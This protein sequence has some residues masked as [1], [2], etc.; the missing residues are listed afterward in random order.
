[1]SESPATP[2]PISPVARREPTPTTLHGITLQDDFR[3]MRDKQSSELLAY[4]EAENAHTAAAMAP[5][6]DLQAKLYAEMLSHIKETDESV[7]YRLG[8]WFYSTRTLEGSQYPIHVRRPAGN[9]DLSSPFDPAQPEQVILDVNLLAEGKPFMSVGAL[10]ICPDG[11]FLAY[12]TDETGFRQYTLHIRDLR[13]GQDLPE[14]AQRVGSATWAADSKTLFYSTEDE[15]TKRQDHIFRHIA[16][17]PCSED[18]IV[19]HEPDERFNVGIGRTRDGAFL[20]IESGSHT[21][22]EYRFLSTAQPQGDFR[23][24]APRTDDQ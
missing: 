18:P 9:P 15:T 21:T 23:L 19:Y 5:T 11:N 16:G 14:S 22:N 3:W 1:M 20:M 24:L 6:E 17:T 7:P 2:V 13:T 12:S 10:A 8:D 4:L